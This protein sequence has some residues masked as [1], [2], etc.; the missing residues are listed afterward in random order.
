MGIMPK[1]SQVV[2]EEEDDNN[3][4]MVERAEEDNEG[5]WMDGKAETHDDHSYN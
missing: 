3:D 1:E 5:V 2:L 4:I